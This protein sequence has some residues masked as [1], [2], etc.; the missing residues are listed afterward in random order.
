MKINIVD[1]NKFK[2]LKAIA[3]GGGLLSGAKIL[4][5]TPSAVHQSIAKLEENLGQKLFHR[6]GKDYILTEV[7]KEMLLIYARFEKDLAFFDEKHNLNTDQMQGTVRVALP[8][9]YS[10]NIFLPLMKS[11]HEK[12]PLVQFNLTVQDSE[13]SLLDIINFKVDFAI[14]DESNFQEFSHKVHR[15]PIFSEELTLACSKDFYKKNKTEFNHINTQK[16][17]VH[18][19]YSTSSSFV[20]NWYKQNYKKNIN[21]ESYHVINNIETLSEAIRLGLGIGIIPKKFIEL[22]GHKDEII[23]VKTN[24]AKVYNQLYLAQSLDYVNGPIIKKFIEHLK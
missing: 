12:Y 18:L 13:K 19:G 24:E 11:F 10:K 9:F 7:G 21:L 5:L 1:F 8:L 3:D 15:T 16:K 6:S 4:G 22:F 17:L 14:I 23:S 20:E 2:S